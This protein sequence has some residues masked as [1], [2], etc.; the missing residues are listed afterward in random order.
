M[1]LTKTTR[2]LTSD[3]NV[4]QRET[5]MAMATIAS[6]TDDEIAKPTHCEGWT[7]G[8]LIAHLALDAD[9]M[10][11]LVTWA[12]TGQEAPAYES[13]EQRD[14]DIEATS[15]LSATEL[16]KA[17][18]QADARLLNALRTLKGGV[19]TKTVPT[20]FSGE[21]DVF[22]L[23]AR[24]TTEVIVH[25]NDL[26]TTWEW[27]EADPDATVDA[28]EVCVQRLQAHPD[29]PGLHIVAREGEE[30]TVGDGSHR[31]EGY[32]EALLPFLV[33]GQVDEGLRYEGD[34]PSLPPW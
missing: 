16:A 7:R 34:S 31:I 8:H 4:L 21:V 13:R 18:E 5:G 12:V 9:A 28:I 11:N 10:A 27:H 22:S 26:G 17:L 24:R 33:R 19:R 30:W 23:P 3:L 14:A 29:S 2:S 6:L 15:Q 20:L 1:T 25:H 32:Y